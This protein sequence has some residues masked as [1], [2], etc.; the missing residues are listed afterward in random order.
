MALRLET[1][2][3]A[4]ASAVGVGDARPLSSLLSQVLVAFTLELD[5]EFERQ[6]GETGYLGARLSL[7]LW[8]NVMRFLTEDGLSVQQLALRSFAAERA[9]KAQLGCLERWGF[10]TL[11]PE[12]P[13]NVSPAAH[14]ERPPKRDGWGSARGIRSA[15]V[16]QLTTMG[17]AAT[18]IWTPLLGE[19]ERRW[20]ARLGAA[21]IVALREAL[22]EVADQ[23]AVEF[24]EGF[25]GWTD[26][27]AIYPTR[28]ARDMGWRPVAVP[29]A[30]LLLA[31][32]IEFDRESPAPLILSANAL[33]VLSETPIA[34]SDLPRLTGGSPETVGIGWQLRP[35]ILELGST[36]SRGSRVRL[37]AR[38]LRAQHAY[39]ELTCDIEARWAARF[40]ADRIRRMVECLEQLF[41]LR[42]GDRLV[43]S[44]G[45][46]PPPGTVRAGV[47][48]PA[49][50]R[51]A[52]GSAAQQRMR[53]LVAQTGW[54]V[55]DPVHALPHYPLWDVN[56]GFGP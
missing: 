20:I 50:G 1:S 26:P 24:P 18:E 21:A 51:R 56:R 43:L 23:L 22:G 16:A 46:V 29:V 35:Y 27:E 17:R 39:R 28:A 12:S 25:P 42:R 33:R 49:L 11:G 4:T 44:E 48:A 47:L 30:Q 19:I 9:V 3:V 31:F 34:A 7:V 38:G 2:T 37:S 5:N 53:D 15:W 13:A 14:L 45:L 52:V 8:C 41:V 32:T 10:V 54:F 55:E 40:G 6:M 36:R